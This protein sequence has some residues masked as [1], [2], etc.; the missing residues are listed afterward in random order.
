[1]RANPEGRN[2]RHL[3]LIREQGP[4]PCAR[5]KKLKLREGVAVTELGAGANQP[6]PQLHFKPEERG[7]TPDWS[8]YDLAS[9]SC[10]RWEGESGRDVEVAVF[11]NPLLAPLPVAKLAPGVV[12][13]SPI[14]EQEPHKRTPSFLAQGTLQSMSRRPRP[15]PH[16][17]GRRS[18]VSNPVS[19]W[20]QHGRDWP[21]L[22]SRHSQV[23]LLLPDGH[24]PSQVTAGPEWRLKGL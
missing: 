5:W 17:L 14:N 3:C 4:H 9:S 18:R 10:R 20:R 2:S 8:S 24:S 7:N 15:K 16:A 19:S 22:W 6:G 1:M 23:S 11:V 12:R 13:R 21:G